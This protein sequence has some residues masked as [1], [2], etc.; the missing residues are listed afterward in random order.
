[1]KKKV[2]PMVSQ[3]I[4]AVAMLFLTSRAAR[5]LVVLFNN[6]QGVFSNRFEHILNRSPA[7]FAIADFNGDGS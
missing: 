3:R 6:G 1:M 2:Q 7:A 4:S 5:K